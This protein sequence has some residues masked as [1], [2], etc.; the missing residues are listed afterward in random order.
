MFKKQL[1]NKIIGFKN[2]LKLPW[3]K[4]QVWKPLNPNISYEEVH[5]DSILR[6]ELSRLKVLRYHVMMT[7]NKNPPVGKSHT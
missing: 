4:D 7:P 6:L 3:S 1:K 2:K 5:Y